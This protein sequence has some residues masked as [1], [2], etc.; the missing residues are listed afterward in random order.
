MQKD[1]SL[2]NPLLAILLFFCANIF[3]QTDTIF[4][5]KKE[6][7]SCTVSEIADEYVKFSINGNKDKINISEIEK[8]VFK[9]GLSEKFKKKPEIFDLESEKTK[10]LIQTH[11][12]EWG[13][14]LLKCIFAKVSLNTT[15]VIWDQ[16]YK[17]LANDSIVN[18]ALKTFYALPGFEDREIITWK[19]KLNTKLNKGTF[20]FIR[21]TDNTSYDATFLNCFY[22]FNKAFKAETQ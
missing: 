12:N 20:S 10:A 21:A 9:N 18:I 16:T 14:K 5:I 19:A 3:S 1:L 8:I 15:Y 17:E 6:K 11:A 4:T 22:K 13:T 7:I 2:N